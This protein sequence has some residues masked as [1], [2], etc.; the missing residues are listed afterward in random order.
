MKSCPWCHTINTAGAGAPALCKTC[1]HRFD[2][3]RLSCDCTTCVQAETAAIQMLVS[4]AFLDLFGGHARR[5]GRR[6][7]HR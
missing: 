4:E 1:G 7:V 5:S 2:V 6:R 3:C